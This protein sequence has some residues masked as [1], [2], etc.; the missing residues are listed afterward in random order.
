MALG[1][2]PNPLIAST[3]LWDWIPIREK[4]IIADETTGATSKDGPF[5]QEEMR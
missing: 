3:N 1:T 5:T 2:S 4:C